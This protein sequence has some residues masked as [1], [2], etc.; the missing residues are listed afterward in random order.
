VLLA[1][2]VVSIAVTPLTGCV[3][4]DDDH[5]HMH[6]HDHDHDPDHP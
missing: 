5:D 2:I 1:F 6:D 3:V 4:H